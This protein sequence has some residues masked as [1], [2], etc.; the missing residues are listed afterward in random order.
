MPRQ[1]FFPKFPIIK[2]GSLALAR[3]RSRVLSSHD[4]E[5][6][7]GHAVILDGADLIMNSF[8][9]FFPFLI[10]SNSIRLLIKAH[11]VSS[12]ISYPRILLFQ[13]LHASATT[14]NQKT[15]SSTRHIRAMAVLVMALLYFLGNE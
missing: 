11:I 10:L 9:L 5:T 4:I 14:S 13:D 7:D 1:L 6:Y 15:Q 12:S 3:P 8:F 2:S